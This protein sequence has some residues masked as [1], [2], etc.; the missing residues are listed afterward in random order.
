LDMN[1]LQVL[2]C[3]RGHDPESPHKLDPVA[4]TRERA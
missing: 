3:R 1:T 4:S 2:T